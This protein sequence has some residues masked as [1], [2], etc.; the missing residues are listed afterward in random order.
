MF[1]QPLIKDMMQLWSGVY[2]Y[3]GCIRDEFQLHATFL[4]SIH[5]YPGYATVS[6]RSTRGFYTCVHCDEN[7][8][9]KSLKNKVGYIGHSRFLPRDH[10]YRKSKRFNNHEE[11]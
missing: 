3:D 6:G 5:D 8:C 11:L 10:P 4:W 9:Y 2:T 7:P 1:M